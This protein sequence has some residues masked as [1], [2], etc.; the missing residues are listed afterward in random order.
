MRVSGFVVEPHKP[1]RRDEVDDWRAGTFGLCLLIFSLH[2]LRFDLAT[3]DAPRRGNP[4]VVALVRVR[5]ALRVGGDHAE[6]GRPRAQWQGY[7]VGSPLQLPA[8]RAGEDGLVNLVRA[9]ARDGDGEFDGICLREQRFDFG[10]DRGATTQGR[11]YRDPR[12]G[13]PMCCCSWGNTPFCSL[14]IYPP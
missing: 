14:T 9:F 12:R 1:Q 7:H 8:K 3:V 13:N 5:R 4:Y 2:F 11:P 6:R 10:D